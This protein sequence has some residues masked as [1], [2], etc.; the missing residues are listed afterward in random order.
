MMEQF[1]IK[2]GDPGCIGLWDIVQINRQT[3]YKR[4]LKPTPRLPSAWVETTI[5]LRRLFGYQA[6]PTCGDHKKLA[7]ETKPGVIKLSIH[8]IF[9]QLN[10]TASIM[11]RILLQTNT[12]I[13]KMSI[14]PRH[15]TTSCLQHGDLNVTI[16]YY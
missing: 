5:F 14:A 1:W 3:H 11:I 10:I 4:R 16:D 9:E 8:P 6:G 13:L 12:K 7:G 2:F 15:S